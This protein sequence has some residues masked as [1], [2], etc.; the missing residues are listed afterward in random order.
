[1]L[2]KINISLNIVFTF[3]TIVLSFLQSFLGTLRGTAVCIFR[4]I[5]F[6]TPFFKVT[7]TVSKRDNDTFGNRKRF[8]RLVFD[9]DPI[10]LEISSNRWI[11]RFCIT[12][13]IFSVGGGR[14]NRGNKSCVDYNLNLVWTL[15][16]AKFQRNLKN[17]L[18]AD[19]SKIMADIFNNLNRIFCEI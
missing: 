18:F 5:V 10:L 16:E 6:L 4:K 9:F 13:L 8:G 1:M 15:G 19:K 11:R 7:Q 3:E 12:F 14:A 17:W 2:F